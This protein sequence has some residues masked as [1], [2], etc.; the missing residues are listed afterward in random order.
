MVISCLTDGLHLHAT[1]IRNTSPIARSGAVGGVES[2]SPPW[3]A[4]P[5]RSG[6]T[7]SP[8][9]HPGAYVALLLSL[10][11]AGC[12]NGQATG[13]A[14]NRP[15]PSVVGPPRRHSDSL[16]VDV[17]VDAT[18]SMNGYTMRGN[19]S[20][21]SFLDGL[22]AAIQD[23]W[24]RADIHFFRF[25][26][27][28]Q[29]LSRSAFLK[30]KSRDFYTEKITGIDRAISCEKP[31]VISVVVTD[32]FQS[33]GDVNAIVAQIKDRC[34]QRRISAAILGIKSAF[35]GTVFDARVPAYHYASTADT[36]SYRPFYALMFGDAAD[37]EFLLSSLADRLG[38]GRDYVMIAP[39][40]V[41]GYQVSMHKPAKT[42]ELNANDQGAYTF[43]FT[44][45]KG[46]QRAGMLADVVIA[47]KPGTPP[48]RADKLELSSYRRRLDGDKKQ[49]ADSTDSRDITLDGVSRSGDT[50]HLVLKLSLSD[51]PGTY[52]YKLLLRTG[53]VGGFAS[54]RWIEGFSSD[55][56]S[57]AEDANKTLNLASFVLDLR[58]ASSSVAQP[59]VAAWTVTM[60]KL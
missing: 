30:A 47:P 39:Y 35:D 25:G 3:A 29:E 37:L 44:L 31:G 33:E 6:R 23:S 18:V 55:N 22:E 34:F 13:T 46:E 40:I 15:D 4:P 12:P 9:R 51:S 10:A 50:L 58:R 49:R 5:S 27:G 56:P 60:R 42:R 26:A 17:L 8:R 53:A 1:A 54:P 20:Y 41:S 48:F 32:L 21:V 43:G 52:E 45:R 24:R 36:S 16:R 38:H 7:P 14:S 59:A 28:A 2:N 57:P 11:L 19:S